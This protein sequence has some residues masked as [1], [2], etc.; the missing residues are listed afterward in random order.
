LAGFSCASVERVRQA[1]PQSDRNIHHATCNMQQ[2]CN[3][4]HQRALTGRGVPLSAVVAATP[5]HAGLVATTAAAMNGVSRK[6]SADDAQ[7]VHGIAAINRLR[8][9]SSRSATCQRSG[10]KPTRKRK[11]TRPIDVHVPQRHRPAQR[12]VTYSIV[13]TQCSAALKRSDQTA[14]YSLLQPTT[15]YYR[16]TTAYRS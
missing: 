10:R 15:A 5:F 13:G 16:P 1:S 14:H 2:G 8:C 9:V 6:E 4:E 3:S 11:R 7:R 12:D